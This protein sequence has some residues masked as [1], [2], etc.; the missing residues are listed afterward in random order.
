ML[1][2]LSDGMLSMKIHYLVCYWSTTEIYGLCRTNLA[3]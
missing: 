2:T 3:T 1:H